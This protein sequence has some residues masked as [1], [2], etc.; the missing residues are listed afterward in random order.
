MRTWKQSRPIMIFAVGMVA[1]SMMVGEAAFAKSSLWKDI[2]VLN[3]YIRFEVNGRATG[4]LSAVDIGNVM[5]V[6]ASSVAS[7]IGAH[8]QLVGKMGAVNLAG[9]PMVDHTGHVIIDGAM[10]PNMVPI[11][12]N[13]QAYV[14]ANVLSSKL[15]VQSTWSN[16]L[17]S[18]SYDLSN[19]PQLVSNGQVVMVGHPLTGVQ[20]ITYGGTSYLPANAIAQQLQIP[21]EWNVGTGVD[22]FGDQTAGGMLTNMMQ[23]TSVAGFG[24]NGSQPM[25]NSSMVMGGTTYTNGLQFNGGTGGWSAPLETMTYNLNGD[26]SKLSGIVGIDDNSISATGVNVSIVGD[27]NTLYHWTVGTG[28]APEKFSVNVNGVHNLQIVLDSSNS[29]SSS[30]FTVD[31]AN[32]TLS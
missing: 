32:L 18:V 8:V 29:S 7:A 4:R 3:K 10:S 2:K 23:P 25:I 22:Y 31:F 13:G 11:L 5:Y 21:N 27:G 16:T 9:A 20:P 12:Y 30:N 24:S 14:Q 19:V 28:Q 6:P 26:Y 1:G 17:H 15:G